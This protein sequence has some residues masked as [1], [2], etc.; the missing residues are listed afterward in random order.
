MVG[1]SLARL[2]VHNVTGF[3]PN[4]TVG[5]SRSNPALGGGCS[6]G[7]S[8]AAMNALEKLDALAAKRD[9]LRSRPWP[10]YTLDEVAGH[11]HKDDCWIVVN[12]K[13]YDMTPH[14]QNHEGWMGSGKVSTLLA[15]LSAMGTDC[16]DDFNKT[17]DARGFRELNAY[18][19][20]PRLIHVHLLSSKYLLRRAHAVT[21][22][23]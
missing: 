13:V 3:T 6:H 17:H 16:T 4:M 1:S 20:T 21:A 7:C 9:Q 2:I 11:N 10:T 22:L 14:V 18:Q 23:R 12:D 8:C 19:V 15:I 5:G